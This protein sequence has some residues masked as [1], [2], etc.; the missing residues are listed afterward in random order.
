MNLSKMF[1]LN[2]IKSLDLTLIL[3]KTQEQKVQMTHETTVVRYPGRYPI[4]TL[5]WTLQRTQKKRC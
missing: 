3:Q 2:L 5:A 1:N 4:R